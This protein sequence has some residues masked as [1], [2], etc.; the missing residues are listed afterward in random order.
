MRMTV[1]VAGGAGYIGSHTAKRLKEAGHFPVVYDNCS[2]GHKSVIDILKIPGIVADLNDS[3]SLIAALR[4]YKIDTVMH[5]AAYA[6]VGYHLY[7]MAADGGEPRMLSPASGEYIEASFSPNGKSL[8]F[9]YELQ[10]LEVYHLPRLYKVPW[11]AG[12]EPVLVARD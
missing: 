11:P 7:R 1:L 8:F 3:A 12:G 10:D 4:E 9:K 6:Y 2:R 5:F